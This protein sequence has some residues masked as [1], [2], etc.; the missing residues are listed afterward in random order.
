MNDGFS[1]DSANRIFCID[2]LAP[3]QV[4]ECQSAIAEVGRSLPDS[5]LN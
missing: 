4:G 2:N 1:F 5:L 3:L